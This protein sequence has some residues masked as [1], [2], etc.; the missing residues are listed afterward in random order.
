M[1]TAV[2]RLKPC[3][4]QGTCS[5]LDP[6]L[7]SD[8][9]SVSLAA[10]EGKVHW[11]LPANAPPKS[12]FFI[13]LE[14]SGGTPAPA[15]GSDVIPCCWLCLS[16]WQLRT[17][18]LS[19]GWLGAAF[20]PATLPLTTIVRLMPTTSDHPCGNR[21]GPAPRPGSRACEAWYRHPHLLAFLPQQSVACSRRG[22]A[23]G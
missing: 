8:P 21:H 4:T 12:A 18:T 14:P 23:H 19:R 13:L 11:R 9:I 7:R 3:H 5:V 22:T 20:P 2:R 17:G 1:I 10:V 16:R 6:T 15:G